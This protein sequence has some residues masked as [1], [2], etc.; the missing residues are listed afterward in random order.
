MTFDTL[1]QKMDGKVDSERQ[2]FQLRDWKST[3]HGSVWMSNDFHG[4]A[5]DPFEVAF[6]FDGLRVPLRL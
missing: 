5:G 1:P 3:L 2:W 4:A 6:A